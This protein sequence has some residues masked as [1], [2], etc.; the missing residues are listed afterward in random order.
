[1]FFFEFCIIKG[2]TS[3][4][5]EIVVQC[6]HVRKLYH[7]GVGCPLKH[8]HINVSFFAFTKVSNLKTMRWHHKINHLHFNA[9]K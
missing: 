1:M 5:Q 6:D 2:R 3:S 9:M 7:V 8:S 4:C